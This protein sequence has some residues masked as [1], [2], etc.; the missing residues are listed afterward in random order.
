MHAKH[1][2]QGRRTVGVIPG[3]R[4]PCASHVRRPAHRRL[5]AGTCRTS[6]SPFYRL[7]RRETGP[8]LPFRG[9]PRE[10]RI[11]TRSPI[12]DHPSLHQ[13]RFPRAWPPPSRT[14]LLGSKRY[15]TSTVRYVPRFQAGLHQGF[16]TNEEQKLEP[17]QMDGRRSSRTR[18]GMRPP[19]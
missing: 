8:A 7:R 18:R 1:K 13:N 19:G 11:E 4:P 5:T 9:A 3:G 14:M 2:C 15:S 6:P 17:S 16:S 12:I 10:K